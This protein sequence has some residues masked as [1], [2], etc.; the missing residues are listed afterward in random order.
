M[1]LD[2]ATKIQ[3][4]Y[5][6]ATKLLG[7]ERAEF[8]QAT[9]REDDALRTEVQTLLDS[10]LETV[11][12]SEALTVA[13]P[14]GYRFTTTPHHDDA[15]IGLSS[16]P[17]FADDMI[18][19]QIG[20]YKIERE[21]GRG[22]MG[23][24]YMAS[25]ADKQF[26]TQ[27]AIKLVK[28]GMG[29]DFVIRRFLSE[30]QIL[31][32]LNHP[33]IARLLDGGAT[34]DGSPYFVMEY[35]EGLP[36]T[37]YC[38]LHRLTTA[39]RLKLF[40]QVCS[41][42]QYAHQNLIVHRDIKP[43]NIL[44]TDKGEVK[45]LDFGIAKLL[46]PE[47]SPTD[48][49]AQFG[50]LMTPDYASPEQV[51][52]APITTASDI[53]SLG[54]LLYQLLTGHRPYHITNTSPMEMV[55]LIC[56]QEPD[57]PS[58]VINRSITLATQ[59]E[60][61]EQ[62]LTPEDVSKLH[63]S[64]PDKLRKQ[65]TGDLDNI[66]LKAMRKEPLRR[67]ASAEQFSEDIRRHLEGRTVTARPDTLSYR[68]KKFIQ[69]NKVGVAAAVLLVLT[70]L[71]GIIGTTWQA[72]AAKRE[73]VRAERRFGDVRKLANS[74]L[75]EFHD[76][77]KDLAGATPARELVV[78][79]ALE[80][81]DSLSQE[82]GNDFSLQQDLATAY[83]K[84]GDVQ[85]DPY[86][87]SLGDTASALD[88]YRKSLIIREKL[89]TVASTN[90]V[91][92][93][94][95][96]AS[97]FKVGSMNWLQGKLDEAVDNQQKAIKINEELIASDPSNIDWQIELARNYAYFGDTLAE[98]GNLEEAL[99]S[100][101]KS[102]AMRQELLTTST[103]NES[104]KKRTQEL[105]SSYIKLGDVLWRSGKIAETLEN[106]GKAVKILEP[107]L[108]ENPA[109]DDI[110]SR[111]EGTYQ[112][113][114]EVLRRNKEF[115]QALEY[116][117]KSI[118]IDELQVLADP[119]NAVAR[120]NLMGEYVSLGITL[121]DMEKYPEAVKS[122]RKAL[123][124][125]SALTAADPHN[126]QALSDVMK[127]HLNLGIIMTDTKSWAEADVHLKTAMEIAEKLVDEASGGSGD[128]KDSLANISRTYA[129]MKIST[130]EVDKAL[131]ILRKTLTVRE[132]L[133]A[134]I[135][136]SIDYRFRLA[137]LWSIFGEAYA[138]QAKQAKTPASKLEN[139]Q[140]ARS[141][142]QRSL[143]SIIKMRDE[144]LLSKSRLTYIPDLEKEVARCDTELA[145]KR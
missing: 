41:A 39:E 46:A 91:I 119:A 71:G 33:N 77:V 95:L 61:T 63:N 131:E 55:R 66:I 13:A 104:R 107:L 140:E 130:G 30:R 121:S 135:P 7:N 40:Q 74:F 51:K 111:L 5:K 10:Q 110:H 47:L 115:T 24:V 83:E 99:A 34:E 80:Y 56:E 90:P 76:S 12:D 70:L 37:Q 48:T 42:I 53:Y 25:R 72:V 136:A 65:L 88:S 19:R 35:I 102:L 108:A 32:Y 133:V 2:R 139:W 132:S 124:I 14:D 103:D 79:R 4:I 58:T 21:V 127:I 98:K 116:F 3:E 49:T 45:L 87:A 141:W 75:F 20:A 62:T 26:Q 93:N 105:G 15:T 134:E 22:G 100:E 6:E 120:R 122:Y 17:M 11:L 112:R 142:Y 18:G 92:R 82:A 125:A 117:E 69:R 23:A 50:R 126:Q 57:R 118:K 85:G 96:A 28:H 38:D 89:A 129:S 113:L 114:G 97:Y 9:C 143:D 81:L 36:I 54:V 144:N 106:Y 145:K 27:V 138:A 94:Q 60:P 101:N 73:R 109:D 137:D 16:V 31:A 68:A 29:N 59:K 86:T 128:T 123:E 78:K 64:Q 43:G 44:V 67:Y 1:T 84:V 8:I 52:G